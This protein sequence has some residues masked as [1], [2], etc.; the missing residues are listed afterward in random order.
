MEPIFM[1]KK[2]SP[3]MVKIYPDTDPH[4]M[5]GEL[6]TVKTQETKCRHYFLRSDLNQWT[7]MYRRDGFFPVEDPSKTE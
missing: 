6:L 2:H 7:A 5:V 3:L 4:F 1:R